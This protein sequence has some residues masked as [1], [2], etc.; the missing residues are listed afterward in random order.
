MGFLIGSRETIDRLR[1]VIVGAGT[2]ERFCRWATG[3]NSDGSKHICDGTLWV[4]EGLAQMFVPSRPNPD[5]ERAGLA[6]PRA[7][8]ITAVVVECRRCGRLEFFRA[9]TL[10]DGTEAMDE[11]GRRFDE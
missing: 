6:R 2:N 5:L 7:E 8:P 9:E 3:Y 1:N 10:L 4:L 11:T